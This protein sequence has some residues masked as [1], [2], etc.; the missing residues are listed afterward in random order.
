MIQE[1]ANSVERTMKTLIQVICNDY[2]RNFTCELPEF[3]YEICR[4]TK[5]RVSGLLVL[6]KIKAEIY[7]ALTLNCS[8]AYNGYVAGNIYKTPFVKSHYF[9]IF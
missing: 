8:C 2:G 5:A 4:C 6:Y 7:H 3:K 1:I 9:N